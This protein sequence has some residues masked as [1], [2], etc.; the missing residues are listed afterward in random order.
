MND[1]WYMSLL[2]STKI[3]NVHVGYG[4]KSSIFETPTKTFTLM[5]TVISVFR[6]TF[7]LFWVIW[8][9]VLFKAI[10]IF[11]LI[12][13]PCKH[14]SIWFDVIGLELVRYLLIVTVLLHYLS[15]MNFVTST[16]CANGRVRSSIVQ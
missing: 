2:E 14:L 15:R 10:G 7:T 4:T 8:I 13:L 11:F 6:N 9:V 12:L 3:Y 1:G 5:F 16:C